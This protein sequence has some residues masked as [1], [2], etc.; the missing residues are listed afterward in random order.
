[1][2]QWPRVSRLSARLRSCSCSSSCF[3]F[4]CSL[5]TL[6]ALSMSAS[7]SVSVFVGGGAWFCGWLVVGEVCCII[8]SSVL[9]GESL[10]DSRRSCVASISQSDRQFI[11]IYNLNDFYFK[12]LF[13]KYFDLLVHSFGRRFRTTVSKKIKSNLFEVQMQAAVY[14]HTTND[15]QFLITLETK[16]KEHKQ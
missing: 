1:M 13:F 2:C 14:K 9:F 5:Y 10:T 12:K 3:L 16:I 7:S 4:G 8:G 15:K 11:S 6:N